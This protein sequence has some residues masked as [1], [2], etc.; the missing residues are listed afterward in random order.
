MAIRSSVESI[1]SS[2]GGASRPFATDLL[3]AGR[4][5]PLPPIIPDEGISGTPSFRSLSTSAAG[6]R[7]CFP[8]YSAPMS[9][10]SAKRRISY[11]DRPSSFAAWPVR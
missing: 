6:M 1:R 3:D 10:L 2:D 5:A 11:E 4:A 7:H 8:L 9:P